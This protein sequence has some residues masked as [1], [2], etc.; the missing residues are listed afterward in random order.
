M[1][2][3]GQ[4]SAWLKVFY[5]AR[6]Y[7][8]KRGWSMIQPF[9]SSLWTIVHFPLFCGP[10][11]GSSSYSTWCAEHITWIFISLLNSRHGTTTF[12]YKKYKNKFGMDGVF[13]SSMPRKLFSASKEGQQSWEESVVGFSGITHYFLC[14]KIRRDF[15]FLKAYKI[16]FHI[17]W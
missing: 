13:C 12:E 11:K 1:T 4:N 15:F 10:I 5:L 17:R 14:T 6:S 16:N 8:T 2:I 3:S 7:T 9:Q